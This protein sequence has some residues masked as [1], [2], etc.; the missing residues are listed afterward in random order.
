M[1]FSSHQNA[2]SSFSFAWTFIDS[3]VL[4]LDWHCCNTKKHIILELTVDLE[5]DP[6]SRT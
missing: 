5:R 6:A 1:E 4:V 3:T 2:T